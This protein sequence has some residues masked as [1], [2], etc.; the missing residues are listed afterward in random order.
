MHTCASTCICTQA[1]TEACIHVHTCICTQAHTG[2]CTYVQIH[3]YAHGHTE[4]LVHMHTHAY[5]QRHTHRGMHTCV[6]T[7]KAHSLAPGVGHS[8]LRSALPHEGI[9]HLMVCFLAAC[10][11]SESATDPGAASL[12]FLHKTLFCPHHPLFGHLACP[13]TDLHG[14]QVVAFSTSLLHTHSTPV[15]TVGPL[16]FDWLGVPAVYLSFLLV[17]CPSWMKPFPNANSLDASP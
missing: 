16:G 4:R 5:A 17:S 13:Q 1:H 15:P 2:S 11:A 8:L 3:V 6:Y 9:N 14:P 7:A 12:L 10:F